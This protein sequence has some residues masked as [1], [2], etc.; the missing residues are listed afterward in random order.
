LEKTTF[1]F[2]QSIARFVA[3]SNMLGKC[4]IVRCDEIPQEILEAILFGYEQPIYGGIIIRHKGLL[5]RFCQGV[6]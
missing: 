2:A 4:L 5:Q 6:A 1:D 3:H